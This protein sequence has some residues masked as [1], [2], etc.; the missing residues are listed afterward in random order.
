M[1]DAT[2]KYAPSCHRKFAGR[3]HIVTI[4]SANTS[5]MS[6]I[7]RGEPAS[8]FGRRGAFESKLVKVNG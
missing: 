8:R 6:L 4:T 5:R 3:R 7:F 2:F 1:K